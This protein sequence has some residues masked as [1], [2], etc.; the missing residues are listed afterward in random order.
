MNPTRVLWVVF[1]LLTPFNPTV[2]QNSVDS[3]SIPNSAG[4]TTKIVGDELHFELQRAPELAEIRLPRI[5]NNVYGAYWKKSEAPAETF[6]PPALSDSEYLPPVLP[7]AGQ[8]LTF[9]QT[10]TE[11]RPC[12]QS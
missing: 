1:A 10:P 8:H 5:N 11:W 2:A 6:D 7:A 3:V 12:H 9:S 4:V